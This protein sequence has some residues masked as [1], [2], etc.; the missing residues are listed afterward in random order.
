MKI[1]IA[2][3]GDVGFHISKLLSNEKHNIVLID[4]DEDILSIAGNHLDIYTI[5]GDSSSIDTLKQAEVREADI[6][7]G[8][9]SIDQNNLISCIFAKKLGA[10]LTIA[11]V[12]NEEF[13]TDQNVKLMQSMGVDQIINPVQLAVQ[14]IELL[15]KRYVMTNDYEFEEGKISLVGF[16]LRQ[17][18][19]FL[20]YSVRE[21][22]H[23][24]IQK[25]FKIIAIRRKNHTIIPQLDTVLLENDQIFLLLKSEDAGKLYKVLGIEKRIIKDIMILGGTPLSIQVAKKLENKYKITMVSN[26]TLFCESCADSLKKTLVIKGNPNDFDLLEDEGLV[27]MD[28]FIALTSNTETNILTCLLAGEMGVMKTI[29]MVDN[30][31]YFA[32]SRNLGVNTLINKKLLAANEIFRIIRKGNVEDLTTIHGVDGEIIEFFIDDHSRL[33]GTQID[34]LK[35]PDSIILGALLRE[36]E[37]FVVF[38]GLQF[39]YGDKVIVFAKT[40]AL[41][42]VQKIFS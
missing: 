11:R 14:E 1:I 39:H 10:K 21:I 30:T 36:N 42:Q 3:A 23:K 2:G 9:T 24:S 41:D 32:V 28:I 7:I 26:D 29:A 37:C 19:Y 38:K 13:S 22:Y 20:N 8:T 15:V 6:F 12:S 35:L 16:I 5:K 31:A 4:R 34:K 27:N 33:I 25:W 40:R 17:E 18:P